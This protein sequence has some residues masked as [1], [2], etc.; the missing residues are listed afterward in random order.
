MRRRAAFRLRKSGLRGTYAT[1]DSPQGHEAFGRAKD[2]RGT[3]LFGRPGRGKTYAACCAVRLAVEADMSAKL[4]TAKD[5]L[6][7]VREGYG[8]GDS[9][10]IRFARRYDL[11]AL[12]DLGMERPTPWVMET[13]SGLID[14]RVKDGLPT[15]VTSNYALGELGRLWGGIEGARLVSRLGGAC[16][17][18]EMAGGDRRLS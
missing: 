3:Y 2:G 8:T 10:A 13:L 4:V 17:P 5:L 6:D 9:D 1:A 16:D 12:D 14:S 7:T 15:I 18:V 11:L